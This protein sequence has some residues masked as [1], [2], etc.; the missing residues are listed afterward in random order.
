MNTCGG[1]IR[2]IENV[3]REIKRLR[4]KIKELKKQK[5]TAELHLANTMERMHITEVG[6][7]KLEKIKPKEKVK[8]KSR[9]QQKKEAL[10][11]FQEVGIPDPETFYTELERRK[12]E[13]ALY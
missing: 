2:E 13:P 6:K 4:L 11:L 7:I 5:M 8:R 1:Y 3:E 9:K 12:K 10:R